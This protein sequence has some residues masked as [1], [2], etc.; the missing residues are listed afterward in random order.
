MSLELAPE[1]ERA[2]AERAAA[3]GISI[4][5]LLSRYFRP[6]P[7]RPQTSVERVK[8]LLTQWQHMDNTPVA[9]PLPNDGSMTPSEALFQQ[10]DHEDDSLSEAERQTQED[11]WEEF[12]RGINAER[13][14]AGMRLIF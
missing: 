5:E 2:V 13:A 1:V 3:E 6:A 9:R 11:L 4:N 8:S 10:W 12:K 7:P 14:A